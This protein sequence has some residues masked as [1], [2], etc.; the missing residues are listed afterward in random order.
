MVCKF[1]IIFFEVNIRF[2][3][4]VKLKQ[5]ISNPFFLLVGSI[6]K[7][8]LNRDQVLC[9][10]SIFGSSFKY[11]KANS[12]QIPL[13]KFLWSKES[14]NHADSW[15]GRGIENNFLENFWTYQK[16]YF[17]NF[18]NHIS[19]LKLIILCNFNSLNYMVQNERF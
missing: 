16:L 18:I 14:I 15:G 4:C 2:A 19:N 6:K 10:S 11:F 1:N 17:F 13:E 3:V 8:E 5:H 12:S 9:L 7:L